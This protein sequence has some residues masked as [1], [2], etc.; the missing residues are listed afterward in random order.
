VVA[1]TAFAFYSYRKE[2]QKQ[3]AQARAYNERLIELTKEMHNYQDQQRRFY[4]Y[5]YP[6]HTTVDRIVQNARIEVEKEKRTLRG[7]TRLWE[8]R[9]DDDD[10]GVIRLGMGTLASTVLYRVGEIENMDDPLARAAKKLE[11]DSYFVDNIPVIVSLRPPPA[12]Q[13]EGDTSDEEKQKQEADATRTPVTHALGIAGEK[14]AVYEFTHSLLAHFVVF[15]APMDA[16]LYVLAKRKAPWAWL[17]QLPHSIADEQNTYTCF[18]EEIDPELGDEN[19]F[20]DTEGNALDQ[21]LEGI[22]RVLATRKIRLQDREENEGKGNPTAPFL[23][24][25]VDLLDSIYDR[26]SLLTDLEAD[27]AITLLLEQGAMLGA[28]VVFLVPERGKVPSG[29]LSVI[30]VERTTPATNSRLKQFERLHFRYAEVGVNSFRYVGQ[31]DAVTNL[32]EMK[33]LTERL[34][35]LDVRQGFGANLASTVP[36]LDLMEFQ[37]VAALE[38][39]TWDKWQR[40]V[41]PR[42]ADWMRVKIGRM[43]GNKPRTLVFSAKR[44]GVHGMVAGSTGSGK[45]ELLISL[46]MAMAVTYD[47]TV[48]NFVLVDFKGGGAFKDFKDLPHCVDIITNLGLDGVTRMFTAIS[49]EM[50]RR[51]ALNTETSTKNIVDYREKGLHLT[52]KPYPFLFIIIDEFAEM[53]AERPEY[54]AQLE[55]ITRLGRAQGV[56]LLL[57]A[58]RPSGV[59]DQMR[60]NIKYRACLRVETAAESREMLRRGDAAWLPSI[61]GRGYLQVGNDE[62]ELIQVAYTGDRYIDPEQQKPEP[63][64]IWPER[65]PPVED[66]QDQEPPELYKELITRLNRMALTHNITPQRAP[67]PSFLPT[68]L[69]LTET[70]IA[71]DQSLKPLTSEEY[72]WA[73][74]SAHIRMGRPATATLTLNPSVNQWLDKEC[75]WLETL[76]WETH[77][78]RPVVGLIDNPYAARQLP[79]IADLPQGHLVLFGASGWGKTTFIRTL[80]VS[81]AASHSTDHAHIYVLDLGGR[82]LKALETLPHVGA[83]IFPDEEGF[84]ERVEQLLRELDGIV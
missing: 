10:F 8:R 43:A 53:I 45:S 2:K 83:V 79:L 55:T 19:P 76:D 74:D 12:D 15:H 31:A 44:D 22:R 28:A 72:I 68:H 20:D 56:S 75:G 62:I 6:D 61:P 80:V 4:R 64:V 21:F 66:E 50:N 47:P 73:E 69:T 54:K 11:E 78:M 71:Q 23:L 41:D 65:T 34:A 26:E 29:C 59:T 63:L 36:F 37:T 52:H 1:S 16:R 33:K 25:V 30:E 46:I 24:V 14:D 35:E 67:W 39:D 48:L 5:N 32:N 13:D 77:A 57:A 9:A 81:L 70:L 42:L 84:V 82:S 27:A 58:Q 51:Q 49:A 38:A 17:D 40:S 7:E 3:E 18:V 60:S